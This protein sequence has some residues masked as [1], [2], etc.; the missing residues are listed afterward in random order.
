MLSTYTFQYLY[1]AFYYYITIVFLY[2][3]VLHSRRL[4]VLPNFYTLVANKDTSKSTEIVKIILWIATWDAMESKARN[5]KYKSCKI[6]NCNKPQF[7]NTEKVILSI[8]G[9]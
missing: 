9:K 3:I 2:Y 7:G 6:T 1:Y 5:A 8:K 4:A